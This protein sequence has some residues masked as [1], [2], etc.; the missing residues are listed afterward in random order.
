MKMENETRKN[1]TPAAIMVGNGSCQFED[2]AAADALMTRKGT[3]C[4][5]T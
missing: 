2:A 3:V 4:S 1:H 5:V